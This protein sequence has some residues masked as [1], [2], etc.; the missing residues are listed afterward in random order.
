MSVNLD[1]VAEGRSGDGPTRRSWSAAFKKQILEEIDAAPVGGIGVILRRERLYSS[2]VTKWRQQRDAG[3]LEALS[4][5]RGRKAVGGAGELRRLKLENAR[6]SER[7][8]GLEA[9]LEAQ[10][11]VF[12]LLRSLSRESIESK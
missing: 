9:L 11:K 12:T 6:L 7:L 8:E 5:R 2:T 4:R 3:A 10:G 1:L